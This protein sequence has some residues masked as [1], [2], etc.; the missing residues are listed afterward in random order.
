M[1]N[2]RR[3][4]L[5]LPILFSSVALLAQNHPNFTGTWKLNVAKSEI[6]SAGTTELVVEVDH[7]D[8]IL[9]YTV[10]GIAGGQRLEETETFTTDGKASRDSQGVNVRASWDG[11]ALVAVGTADDGSVVYLARLTLSSDGKTITRVFT[12]KDDRE[13]RHEIYE[14][15]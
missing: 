11:P 6:G 2:F 15:Q 9:K 14:K 4:F 3:L 1:N 10:R 8:P 7:K 5:L 13:Q 12:Q